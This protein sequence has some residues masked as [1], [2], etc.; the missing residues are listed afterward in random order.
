MQSLNFSLVSGNRSLLAPYSVALFNDG[1]W[2]SQHDASELAFR[3]TT[4]GGWTDYPT[5][6]N[7]QVALTLPY[8]LQVNDSQLWFNEHDANR[9]AVICCGAT[10]LTEYNMSQVSVA[11]TGIGNA[12]TIDV[13]KNL[14]WFTEWT[15]NK[16]GFVNASIRPTFSISAAN[17][18]LRAVHPG[19]SIQL[20][21]RVSGT[22]TSALSLLFS[23]SESHTAKPVDLSFAANTSESLGPLQG[24][25]TVT[26]AISASSAAAPGTYIVLVTVTDGLTY[27]SLYLP[28][29]VS[30]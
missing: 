20:R 4:S 17:E 6:I 25:K 13:A 26:V 1:L 28:V 18:T 15:G 22:S 21:V 11:K 14:A 5:T 10:T 8:Y 2:V 3:N 16:V 29:T 7:P 12:L 23:D 24:T 27:R 30:R 9:M 19:S